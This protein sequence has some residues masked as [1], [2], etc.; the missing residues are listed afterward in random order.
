MRPRKV[1]Y[2]FSDENFPLPVVER[3]RQ[4]G[5]IVTTLQEQGKA[6]ISLPDPEVLSLASAAQSALLT[7]NRRHFI[8][9]HRERPGHCGIIACTVNP[10]FDAL[11]QQIDQ[12]IGRAGSLTG[13]LLRINRRPG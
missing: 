11:A 9:L 6:S 4:F 10:D 2:L 12:E 8:R 3:L 5:H 13:K 7:M 1:A